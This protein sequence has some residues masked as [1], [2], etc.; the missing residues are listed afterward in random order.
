MLNKQE[1]EENDDE[2]E[3][4]RQGLSLSWNKTFFSSMSERFF[5][6]P[7]EFTL[8]ASTEADLA[9]NLS[10]KPAKSSSAEPR[11]AALTKGRRDLLFSRF[12][13]LYLSSQGCQQVVV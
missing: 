5:C 3:S 13:Q 8:V 2:G 12:A 4:D 6:L 7:R 11:V 9:A 1:K 10:A